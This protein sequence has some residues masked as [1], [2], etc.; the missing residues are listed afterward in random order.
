[1]RSVYRYDL[2]Q[3]PDQ[4]LPI[5]AGAEFLHVARQV[6]APHGLSLWALVD[7]YEGITERKILLRG[8]GTEDD[9]PEG[10]IFIS[11]YQEADGFVWHF[12]D[13][14]ES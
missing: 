6:R 12:F 4:I 8:T 9:I 13:G 10:A 1:M 11:T 14:G 3:V 5:Q 7:P 2:A